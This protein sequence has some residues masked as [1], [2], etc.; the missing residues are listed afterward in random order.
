MKKQ[1]IKLS[2]FEN[3]R[4]VLLNSLKKL[5]IYLGNV[6]VNKL[7]SQKNKKEQV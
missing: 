3:N 4:K 5:K 7:N 6:N 2:L 1:S